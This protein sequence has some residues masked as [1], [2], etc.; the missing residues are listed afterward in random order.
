M[1]WGIVTK[2]FDLN[3]LIFVCTSLVIVSLAPQV[4]LARDGALAVA[5]CSSAGDLSLLPHVALVLAHCY[6]RPHSLS[7]LFTALGN[8]W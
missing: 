5:L 2:Y 3:L 7:N 8:D 6:H 1:M 4:L